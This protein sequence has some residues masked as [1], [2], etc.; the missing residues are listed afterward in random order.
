[1]ILQSEIA[2]VAEKTGV[3]K[4]TI[5]KDWVLGHF[6]NAIFNAKELSNILIFKGG[7]CLRKC[8]FDNYR[9][10]E[11]LDFTAII[12]DFVLDQEVLE[13]LCEQIE[14]TIGIKLHIENLKE[15][16]FNGKKTGFQANIKFWGADHSR[17]QR[18]PEPVRWQ[19]K[20]KIETILFEK[21][22]FEPQRRNIIHPY[23]DVARIS[24]QA[25][26]YDLNEVMSEKMRAMI[27]RSYTAPRDYYDVWFLSKNHVFDWEEVKKAFL[28]KMKFKDLTFE[29]TNQF[30]NEKVEKTLKKHWG[31]SLGAHLPE[32]QLPKSIEVLNDLRIL[33][34]KIFKDP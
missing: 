15:L 20:I 14:S 21:M 5:D 32:G 4:S 24:T 9:F 34:D 27:Q 28:E 25:I 1:M 6:V 16:E 18:P 31:N 2:E 10:S 17:N 8:Y 26:C 12:E 22:L 11:D 19:T 13:G 3:T 33:L 23:S 30:I 7:T 29:H